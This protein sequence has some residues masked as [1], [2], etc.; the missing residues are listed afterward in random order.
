LSI[1]GQIIAFQRDR[2]SNDM[3]KD[4]NSQFCFLNFFV[5]AIS[6]LFYGNFLLLTFFVFLYTAEFLSL[7]TF[8]V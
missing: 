1:F 3:I 2:F 7:L 5:F 4:P 6:Y 8:G